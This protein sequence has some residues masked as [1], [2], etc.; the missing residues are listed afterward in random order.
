MSRTLSLLL[1]TARRGE[2]HHSTIL[3]GPN[4]SLLR[5]TAFSVAKALNCLNGTEGDR[6][7][8]CD[9]IERSLHPDVHWLNV[10]DDRTRIS[11]EQARSAVSDSSLRPFEGRHKVFV[12]DPADSMNA[13]AA[14]ALLKT[15]E[16][17]TPQTIFLLL[18]RYPDLLLP[19]IR[20]RS[21]T[22]LIA[23]AKDAGQIAE[24]KKI[25]LQLARLVE[26]G[27]RDEIR[28]VEQVLRSLLDRLHAFAQNGD[29]AA[30]LSIASIL[31]DGEP[32]AQLAL[33]TE[34]LRD[35]SGLPSEDSIDPEKFKLVQQSI[36]RRSLL[37]AADL[38]LEAIDRL[39]VNA[40]PRLMLERAIVEL[41]K[42]DPGF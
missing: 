36:P 34:M 7:S 31:R 3:H 13:T 26:D 6:C 17:P 23:G 11:A 21:Q 9:R 16:E 14:N 24:S 5:T 8:A 1:A 35:L 27:D 30:L 42:K 4:P 32:K 38:T 10:A 33:V 15:L 29:T 25:P 20:S 18:T 22:V 41:T 19:T 39:L 40:D 12:I 2:L 28:K 37:R